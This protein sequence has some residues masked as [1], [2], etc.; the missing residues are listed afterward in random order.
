MTRTR[1]PDWEP[2]SDAPC[3]PIRSRLTMRCETAAQSPTTA[4]TRPWTVFG[5]ADTVAIV[6]DVDTF[7]NNVSRHLQI[8]NGVD[9][10]QHRA[11]RA[12]RRL[13]HRRSPRRVRANSAADLRRAHRVRPTRRGRGF[14]AA[15]AEPFAND[16][17][18][19]FMGWPDSLRQPLRDW[20]DNNRRAVG[21]PRSHCRWR[22]SPSS[23]TA[24]SAPNSTCAVTARSTTSPGAYSPNMSTATR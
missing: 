4:K 12:R 15:V 18:C 17:S 8:P 1:E 11:S 7:S 21:D 6:D 3:S 23:S 5:H 2:R 20:T 16:V 14:M 24:T 19:A 9:S 22:Q 10:E 13:F